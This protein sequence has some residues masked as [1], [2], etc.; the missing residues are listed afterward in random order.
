MKN[1]KIISV[2]LIACMIFGLMPVKAVYAASPSVSA[3]SS[4]VTVGKTFTVSF[5]Y[6]QNNMGGLEAY[7]SH[8]SNVQ[9]VSISGAGKSNINS[10]NSSSRCTFSYD[11]SESPKSKHTAT[12]TFK[13]LSTGSATITI[14]VIAAD[15]T[16]YAETTSSASTT[17]TIVQSSSGGSSGGSSGSG[18]TVTKSSNNNLSSLTVEGYELSPAFNKN[19][20]EYSVSVPFDVDSLPLQVKLEDSKAKY[21]IEN[22]KLE[23]GETTSVSIIVTAE[24]GK[25][26][27]YV[28]NAE[29]EQDPNYVPSNNSNITSITASAGSLSPVFS[30]NVYSYVVYV[31]YD[32]EEITFTATCEDRKATYN[33]LGDVALKNGKDN[34]YYIVCTAE[35]GS[36][37]IYTIVV[38]TMTYYEDYLSTSFVNSI[39]KEIKSGND[40]VIADFTNGSLAAVDSKIFQTLRETES[41][42]LILRTDNGTITFESENVSAENMPQWYDLTLNDSSVYNDNILPGLGSYYSYIASTNY[43]DVLPGFATFTV[44]TDIMP[45]TNVNVYLYDAKNNEYFRIEK[46]IR[47]GEGGTVTFD[48]DRGGDFVITTK[49]VTAS[50]YSTENINASGKHISN[51]MLIIVA[52]GL[53]FLF[54]FAIGGLIFRKKPSKKTKNNKKKNEKINKGNTSENAKDEDLGKDYTQNIPP[55]VLPE[56]AEK[57]TIP[58]V[59]QRTRLKD[60]DD[61]LAKQEVVANVA[62]DITET[63]ESVE[64]QLSEQGKTEGLSD[65]D[66]DNNEEAVYTENADEKDIIPDENAADSDLPDNNLNETGNSPIDLNNQ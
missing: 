40:P 46:G 48:I 14:K 3:S 54:G 8:S 44:Y 20:T 25:T 52:A 60:D 61:E 30:T 21:S 64:A 28:I 39:I 32:E 53:A 66:T 29:R 65:I 36:A 13:A 9:L 42:T 51:Q 10:V 11:D 45:G 62:S 2:L 16:T 37:S 35:D 55:I 7:V 59:P 5:S 56:E 26:K 50:N 4:T 47:V 31:G 15:Y 24:D 38:R 1:I 57:E 18:T 23:P 6:S 27:T 58:D 22:N 43:K 33:V 12:L 17:V 49:D 41:T 19:T 63:N 34:Y